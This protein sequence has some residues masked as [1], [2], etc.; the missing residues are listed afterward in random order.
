VSPRASERPNVLLQ[1]FLLKTENLLT[2]EVTGPLVVGID[3]NENKQVAHT[4]GVYFYF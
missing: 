3:S 1:A 2:T 4:P